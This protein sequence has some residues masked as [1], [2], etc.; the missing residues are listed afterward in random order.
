MITV[1]GHDITPQRFPDDTYRL[2]D[3]PVFKFYD[4]ENI[5][6]TWKYESNEEMILLYML[7]KHYKEKGHKIQYLSMP[8]IPNARMDRTH[9]ET[10]VFT[11]KYFCEFINSLVFKEVWVF[12]PHSEVSEKLLDR[13]RVFTPRADI[14]NLLDTKLNN[15]TQI[16]YPDAGAA[17]RYSEMIHNRPFTYGTKKRNW[18]TGRIDS[19]DIV[20]DLPEKF[21]V[22]I[23]DDICSYGGTF[24]LAAKALKERGAEHVYLYVS[25]CENVILNGNIPTDTNIDHVYIKNQCMY[26]GSNEKITFL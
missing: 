25:H 20:G 4:D 24:T 10:E 19:L 26:D 14:M 22:L 9:N 5:Q 11:L 6:F 3:M 8:Y 23:V 15:V 7:S 12:D 13:V 17:K 18:E 16:F 1:N 21:D 2:L